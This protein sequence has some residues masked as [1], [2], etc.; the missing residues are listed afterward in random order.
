MFAVG[1]LT[2]ATAGFLAQGVYSIRHPERPPF[3]LLHGSYPNPSRMR[4]IGFIWVG[5]GVVMGGFLIAV[6]Y[7]LL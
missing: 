1:L 2:I 4:V 5:A 7:Q 6:V 3:G